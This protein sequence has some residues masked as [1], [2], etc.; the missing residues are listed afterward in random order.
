MTN[1][2]LSC[3]NDMCFSDG[4]NS[5]AIGLIPK[6]NNPNAIQFEIDCIVQLGLQN[7]GQDLS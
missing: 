4:L 7:N 6:K 2:C 3:L 5:T 1:F